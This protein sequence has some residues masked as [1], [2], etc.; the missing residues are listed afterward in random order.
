MLAVSGSPHVVGFTIDTLNNSEDG[1]GIVDAWASGESDVCVIF[2]NH[3]DK[4]L[5]SSIFF[6]LQ[7]IASPHT[8][9]LSADGDTVYMAEVAEKSKPFKLHKFKVVN[10]QSQSAL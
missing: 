9:A 7:D 1:Q 4:S 5:T 6:A 3:F 10:Q 8:L 2:V